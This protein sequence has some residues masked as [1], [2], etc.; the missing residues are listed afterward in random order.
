MSKNI[1][2]IVLAFLI[3]GCVEQHQKKKIIQKS[4]TSLNKKEVMMCLFSDYNE[5]DKLSYVC[6]S[7]S[8]IGT[9]GFINFPTLFKFKEKCFNE[10]STVCV[11][12]TENS[13]YKKRSFDRSDNVSIN[14]DTTC[15]KYA[16]ERI[17]KKNLGARLGYHEFVKDNSKWVLNKSLISKRRL[18]KN[19]RLPE[20]ISLLEIGR[21]HFAI[22]T[23]DVSTGHGEVIKRYSLFAIIDDKL[24]EVSTEQMYYTNEDAVGKPKKLLSEKELNSL[25]KEERRKYLRSTNYL[26]IESEYEVVKSSKEYYDIKVIT[27]EFDYIGLLRSYDKV[28]I[29]RDGEYV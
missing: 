16:L 20:N 28:Y 13:M 6:D 22:I 5:A 1:F 17:S 25:S 19:G 15:F 27:W 11:I 26:L 7:T 29:C 23:E 21:N 10:D 2:I 4:V 3:V 18:G 14:K 12:I 24:K 8:I 9:E